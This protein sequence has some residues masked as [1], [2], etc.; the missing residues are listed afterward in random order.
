MRCPQIILCCAFAFCAPLIVSAQPEFPDYSPAR[1]IETEGV[2]FP[3]K[4]VSLGIRTGDVGIAVAIDSDGRMTDYLVTAYTHPEFAERAVAALKKWKF[5]PARL[6]GTARNSKIELTFNF[7]VEGLVVVTM[8]ETTD[9]RHMRL[10]PEDMAYSAHTLAQLDRIPIPIRVV[11]PIY[12]TELAKSSRGGHVSV[13]FYIDEQG[14]VRMPSV[15][16]ETDAANEELAAIAVTTVEKWQFEPP[17]LRGKPVLVR[18]WQDFKFK[19]PA[20]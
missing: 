17:L 11:N 6:H 16:L 9:L 18:T 8:T 14:H 15:S 12:P 20:P 4:L 13:E 10:F 7:K 19:P 5:E 2:V 1:Y 3:Q